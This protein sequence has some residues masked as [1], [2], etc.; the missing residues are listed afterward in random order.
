MRFGKLR[1]PRCQ[2]ENSLLMEWRQKRGQHAST[3]A[4]E[5]IVSSNG[6]GTSQ[7]GAKLVELGHSRPPV[8]A[9]L[10]RV[11]SVI[12]LSIQSQ[13]SAESCH[14]RSRCKRQQRAQSGRSVR[15]NERDHSEETTSGLVTMCASGRPG[16]HGPPTSNSQAVFVGLAC[17]CEN[18][19]AP[20]ARA[21][22]RWEVA[23]WPLT[24]RRNSDVATRAPQ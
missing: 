19:A 16:A 8:R 1:E 6:A 23:A 20:R 7:S 4:R 14:M 11:D 21:V 15:A 22:A 9:S 13:L 5:P 10:T 18:A 2:E 17:V 12:N 24:S 3:V